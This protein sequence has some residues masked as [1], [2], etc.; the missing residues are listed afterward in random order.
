LKIDSFTTRFIDRIIG[1]TSTTHPGM[2]LGTPVQDVKDALENP[3]GFG[4]K[5]VMSD[6]DERQKY[7]GKRASVVISITDKKLIQ[8]TPQKDGG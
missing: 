4:D 1:Q 8:A 7:F 3:I 2:R 6:G 5:I